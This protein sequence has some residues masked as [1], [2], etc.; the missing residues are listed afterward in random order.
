M[1][2]ATKREEF[3]VFAAAL[4][5]APLISFAASP[6]PANE[7]IGIGSIESG[8]AW[9]EFPIDEEHVAALV[10]DQTMTQIGHSFM[11]GFSSAWRDLKVTGEINIA[12]YERPSARW[13]SLIWIEQNFTRIYQSFLYPGRGNPYA[14]GESAAFWVQQR[15]ADAEVNKLLFKD[16]DIGKD[17][18]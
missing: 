5:C 1:A 17:E 14:A 7:S 8:S 2:F 6:G 16:P 18:F 4:V 3:R 13:G 10:T 15:I 9:T 12:V 11:Q